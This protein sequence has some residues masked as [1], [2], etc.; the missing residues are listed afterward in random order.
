MPIFGL[1]AWL[2]ASAVIYLILRLTHQD[3]N[4]D[5]V[6]NVVGWGKLIPM[7]VVWLWDWSALG[8]GLYQLI[9][10]AITHSLFE[11]WEA[12]LTGVGLRVLP[13]FLLGLVVTA[14][15]IPLA[16]IFIR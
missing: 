7:P 3:S 6:L 8:L 16:A 9:I 14:V 11:L 2:L 12:W 5:R 4:F 10:M 13:A 15:Y 1:V